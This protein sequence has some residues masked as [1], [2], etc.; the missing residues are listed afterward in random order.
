MRPWHVIAAAA[1]AALVA[2]GAF[3]AVRPDEAPSYAGSPP[4]LRVEL[5]AFAVEDAA[6]RRL[7]RGALRG[8]AVAVTFLD[9]QCTASCPVIAGTIGLALDRLPP[10]ARGRVAAV[11]F[12]VDPAED[13]PAAVRAFLRRHRVEGR[14]FYARGPEPELERLWRAFQVLPSTETGDDDL[15]SAPVR[16]YDA[17]GVWVSTLHAGADLTPDALAHDLREALG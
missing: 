6:G 4:P 8:K 17:D 16:V 2:A 11:A 3:L 14:L 5:P 12:S 10:D 1:A 15:H 9:T 7:T 13:T